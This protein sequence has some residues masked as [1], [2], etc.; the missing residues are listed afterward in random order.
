MQVESKQSVTS[1]QFLHDGQVLASAGALVYNSIQAPF[2][3]FL[4]VP[5]VSSLLL[6]WD[7]CSVIRV[8][9]H[10]LSLIFA[11]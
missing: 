11:A 2:C 5:S 4:S 7:A 9:Q 8:Q 6:S 1:A 3:F 10:W